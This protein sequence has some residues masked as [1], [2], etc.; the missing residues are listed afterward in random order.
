MAIKGIPSLG[1]SKT[2]FIMDSEADAA[3]LPECRPGSY[4]LAVDGGIVYMVNASGV[5]KKMGTVAFSL[6]EEGLF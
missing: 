3:S 1:T 6:A 4:A 2:K 5:W